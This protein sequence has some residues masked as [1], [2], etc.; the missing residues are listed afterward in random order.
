LKT[1]V[2]HGGNLRQLARGAGRPAGAIL[3]F[4]ANLNPLGPPDWLYSLIKTHL[5][6]IAHYPD[7]DCSE[8]VRVIAERYRVDPG[9][10]VVGNGSAELLTFLPKVLGGKRVV[11]PEPAYGD[12]RTAVE[13]AGQ[14]VEPLILSPDDA[15]A[16]DFAKLETRLRDGADR[17]ILG[18]P[19]NP[20][21]SVCSGPALR[22]LARAFPSAII[23]VDE[24]FADFIDESDSLSQK[25]PANAVLLRSLTKFYAIPGLRLGFALL[26][27]SLAGELRKR[28]PP[29]S[30]NALAQAVGVAAL[31]DPGSYARL[32]RELVER[33]RAWL[34]EQ[35]THIGEITVFPSEA[36]FL[37]ARVNRS[38]LDAVALA[39]RLL[40]RGIA[41]RVCDDFVGLDRSYF[42][43]AVR[44]REHNQALCAALRE[45]TGH[46]AAVPARPP[47]A[48]MFQGTGSGAG[49]SILT[50][51][52]CRIL[53]EDG[54]RVAPFKSQ[55][56]S[57]NSFVTRDGCEIGRAQA[58]QAQAAR[59]EPDARMNPVL[60]KPA[61]DTRAQIIVWGKPVGTMSVE[62]YINYKPVAFARALEA[63]RSLASENQVMVLEGAGSPAE[64]NLKAHDI[65]NMEMA[66]QAG[67]RVVVVGDIERG[68]VFAAFTGTLD[69]LYDWERERVSGF[70]VNRFRG[71]A[72]LLGDALTWTRLA[73]G[74]PV[75]GVVPWLRDLGLP[76]EDSLDL[77]R[78]S[79]GPLRSDAVSVAVV[80]FPYLSNFTDF[81]AFRGE[82]D[83]RLEFVDRPELVDHPDVLILPGSKNVF[84]DM[85]FLRDR[86]WVQT[87]AR[88]VAEGHSEIAGICGGFQM[89]GTSL[90]DPHGLEAGQTEVMG[91]GLLPIRTTLH[92]EKTLIRSQARHVSSRLLVEGYQIHHGRTSLEG[93]RPA[94]ERDDGEVIGVASG[95]GPIWGTYLHGIFDNDEF[96]RWFIDELRS[97]RGWTRLGRVQSRYDV[98]AALKRLADAVRASVDVAAIYREIGL[99]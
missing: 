86:G 69:A 33:E 99:S 95:R 9:Q 1:P 24:A 39:R 45:C 37:L 57:L 83:V 62:E 94:V 55:N 91:L 3:D 41:I 29:W 36:N 88:L 47:L 63:Y 81:D 8:L 18:R 27:P 48:L 70:I 82:P 77:P 28:L 49:K 75:F 72:E 2:H 6:D 21:G 4:S 10:V 50:A 42:R 73:T 15:F 22:S 84:S 32:T 67:A 16:L 71:R 40:S 31:S 76:E 26:E 90:S 25:R 61:G 52:F 19:N 93:A 30:V 56:M 98:D 11:I 54:Y 59:L 85:A 35:L 68:G 34:L 46:R 74:R 96:R 80:S 60:M 17:V 13:L 5:P 89:L 51:A 38:H 97:R 65:V 12:Y 66:R 92:P 43:V 58:L 44:T 14:E 79:S 7:P 64:V 87:I 20:T 23:V 53:L 78:G